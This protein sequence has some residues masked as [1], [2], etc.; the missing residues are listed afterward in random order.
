MIL[1]CGYRFSPASGTDP[2][3]I[4]IAWQRALTPFTT[5]NNE[6]CLSLV[7]GVK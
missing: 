4:S 7:F 3:L 1:E 5:S 6:W 2:K